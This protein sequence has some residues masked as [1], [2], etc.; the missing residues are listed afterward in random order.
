[1]STT[2]EVI[3]MIGLGL[4]GS[5]LAER[6]LA[7]GYGVVGYDI[8]PQK[9]QALVERGG[10]G[11]PSPALVAEQADRIALSLLTTPIVLEVLEGPDGVLSASR[12]PTVILD[13]TTG[14]PNETEALAARLA[15]SGVAYLDA[16]ISGSSRQV[17][18][19][20]ATLMVG[21]LPEAFAAC[22]DLFACFSDRVFHLGPAGSGSRAKLATN[23]ILGLNRA[24][25]AEG[26]VFAERL[27]LDLSVFLE[28]LRNSPAYSVAVDTKG[29][30][31]RTGEFTPESRVHQHKKD[32]E[33]I[34]A[35]AEAMDQGLPLSRVHHALLT[36]ALEAGEGELDNAVIIQSI[37]RR[38]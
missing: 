8:D 12:K 38:V 16:T 27:G 9:C 36:E 3:G 1:V 37:R 14:A 20:A 5:A 17:R 11:A 2:N 4:V 30:R 6:L 31:M 26:L 32:V 23:L 15:E 35:C 21:G 7:R 10:T 33:L 28:V 34:L 24:V 29:E 25:L 13:T 22:S 18:D 19:G